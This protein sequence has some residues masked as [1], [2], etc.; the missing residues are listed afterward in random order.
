MCFFL[1]PLNVTRKWTTNTT[2]IDPVG[3]GR[4]VPDGKSNGFLYGNGMWW[5]LGAFKQ[6]HADVFVFPHQ[7]SGRVNDIF[8]QP[9]RVELSIY[10]RRLLLNS[11]PVSQPSITTRSLFSSGLSPQFSI[12]EHF[13]S[14]G[15][16]AVMTPTFLSR[17]RPATI[18][19]N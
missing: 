10:A 1:L 13:E 6:D 9:L 3:Q 17:G 14:I 15:P 11:T 2:R 8:L 16:L 12:A 7:T 19:G 5:Q 18:I 4:I